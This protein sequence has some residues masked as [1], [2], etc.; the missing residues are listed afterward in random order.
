LVTSK[1]TVKNVWLGMPPRGSLKAAESTR[2][3]EEKE[4]EKEEEKVEKKAIIILPNLLS[5]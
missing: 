3:V 5:F 2:K 1:K 4:E